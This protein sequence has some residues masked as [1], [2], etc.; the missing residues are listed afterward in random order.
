MATHRSMV[1]NV[2][3]TKKCLDDNEAYTTL[4]NDSENK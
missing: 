2:D 3:M 4:F 1:N